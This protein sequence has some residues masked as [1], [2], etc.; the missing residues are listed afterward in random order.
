MVKEHSTLEILPLLV[1]PP[2]YTYYEYV[3]KLLGPVEGHKL[4]WCFAE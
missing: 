3:L 1:K 2:H 4:P